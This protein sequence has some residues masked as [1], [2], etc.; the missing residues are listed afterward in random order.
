MGEAKRLCRCSWPGCA[1]ETGKPYTSRWGSYYAPPYLQK[2]VLPGLPEEGW[3]CP[4]HARARSS[5][6]WRPAADGELSTKSCCSPGAL[7]GH[8]REVGGRLRVGPESELE[9][10]L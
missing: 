5:G 10:T 9:V 3:L 7:S 1:E 4:T 6:K 8:P 2:H